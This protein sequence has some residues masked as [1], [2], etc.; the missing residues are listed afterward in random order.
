VVVLQVQ[1]HFLVVLQVCR[2]THACL[3]LNAH[4]ITLLASGESLHR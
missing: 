4:V 3:H 1:L 2:E